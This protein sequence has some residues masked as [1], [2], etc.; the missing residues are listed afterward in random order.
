MQFTLTIELGNEAMRTAEDIGYALRQ[1]AARLEELAQYTEE[2]DGSFTLLSSTSRVIPDGNGNRV[3][4]WEVTEKTV[5]TPTLDALI[6]VY[7]SLQWHVG[8]HGAFGMDQKRLDDAAA[9][10]QRERPQIFK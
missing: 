1:T 8:Q 7:T 5:S 6:D 9:I 3:G 10:L 2:E 4:K